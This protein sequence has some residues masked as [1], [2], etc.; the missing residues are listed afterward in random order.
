MINKLKVTFLLVTVLAASSCS[1][2]EDAVN[3]NL[4]TNQITYKVETLN[5]WNKVESSAKQAR[6]RAAM[7]AS[8]DV[9]K[10]VN[11]W[12]GPLY[13]HALEEPGI[14][15]RDYKDRPVNKQGQLL[16]D[17][18]TGRIIATRGSKVTATSLTKF[19]INVKRVSSD[20]SAETFIDNEEVN[21]EVNTAV[22]SKYKTSADHFWPSDDTS[23]SFYGYYPY[24]SGDY[25]RYIS[26]NNN[27][28]GTTP[29]ITYKSTAGNMKAN[30]TDVK[31]QP[32]LCVAATTGQTRSSKSATPAAVDMTFNHA[33]TAITFAVG[34]DMVPGTFKSITISGV[35]LE[36]DYTYGSG[37][38]TI[39]K[40][41]GSITLNLG[42]DGNGI[43]RSS[44]VAVALTGQ[45]STLLMV[46]QT[47]P[48]GATISMDFDDGNGPKTFTANIG[49]TPW[50]AGS[51]IIYKLST[52]DV[53]NMALGTITFPT[54]WDAAG[55]PKKAYDSG[56]SMGLYSVDDLGN[57]RA[58]NVRITCKITDN[59]KS[60]TPASN[61]RFSP[62][63]KY[64]VY[65]PFND[66]MSSESVTPTASTAE[67][68]FGNYTKSFQVTKNQSEITDLKKNDLQVGMGTADNTGS[69]VK[70][71]N[72]AHENGLIKL[73]L[74]TRTIPTTRIFKAN[75][76]D[77][78]RDAGTTSITL[79]TTCTGTNTPY[80]NG[81]KSF[82]IGKPSTSSVTI[83]STGV[84]S[85]N[86][87]LNWTISGKYTKD[88][89]TI[90][91]PG[92]TRGY[93]YYGRAYDYTGNMQTFTASEAG[94]YKLEVWGAQGG[95]N[96]SSTPGKGGYA[97]GYKN[98]D[99]H[100]ILF[101]CV[102]GQGI[103]ANGNK[104]LDGGYNGGGNTNPTL[105]KPTWGGAGGGG[106][107]HIAT[108]LEGTGELIHYENHQ[109]EVLL[110]AG[111]GGGGDTNAIGGDGGGE[112]G[113]DGSFSYGGKGGTQTAG[114]DGAV[115][116][117]F[118]KGGDYGDSYLV[119]GNYLYD[120]GGCGGGG[121]YGGGSPKAPRSGAGGG[122]SGHIGNV[123]NGQT[124]AG[125]TS[126][127][128]PSGGT[129]VGHEGNGYA[130]ITQLSY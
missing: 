29:V 59:G 10:R 26:V 68:F 111:G 73:V 55:Y 82:V 89:A 69:S 46:P 56:E 121:W 37:W 102:G 8:G 42:P 125:D 97:V 79:P 25:S 48:D 128:S 1:E 15:I 122:G 43:K 51:T 41:K 90:L 17:E 103:Y 104:S 117:T 28:T 101:V 74:G 78:Y 31:A 87:Y 40:P 30:A 66:K 21:E 63:F 98:I 20:N 129:E 18:N 126:F 27:N 32:D 60:W 71:A 35:Y 33:L 45:D 36:G 61:V 24:N 34:S 118:G 13:L 23:L 11:G 116:G 88:T 67:E 62:R 16:A 115:S 123:D 107:T 100:S 7:P 76:T 84:T 6:T 58:Q 106:A 39:N 44:K 50:T 119:Y 96:G 14:H 92:S 127:P 120:S 5:E 2:L 112:N 93:V 91:T 57:L 77:V 124:I 12:S 94:S 64:F 3:S 4:S 47:V 38:S 9:V 130:I 109:T 19:G 75:T 99:K 108:Q 54:T 113:T 53:N 22:D 70:F 105:T 110:V 49:G 95:L 80:V 85:A 83:A 65:Y 114:G 52:K 81:S 72:M 86:R